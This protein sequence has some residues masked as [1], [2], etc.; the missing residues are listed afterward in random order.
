MVFKCKLYLF[1]FIIEI[2]IIFFPRLFDDDP[3]N[4]TLDFSGLDR[5]LPTTFF[6]YIKL[7]FLIYHGSEDSALF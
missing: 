5:D 1:S 3:I 4:L 6:A 2:S 7:T